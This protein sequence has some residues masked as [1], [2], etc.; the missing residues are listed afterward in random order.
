MRRALSACGIAAS[1]LLVLSVLGAYR[2]LTACVRAYAGRADVDLWVAPRGSDNLVRSTGLLPVAPTLA[3]IRATP[4]VRR[5]DPIVR[6]FV[7]VQV[8][9]RRPLTLLALGTA[10][11]GGPPR[12][13]RGRRPRRG[14]EVAFDRA[15]AAALGVEVGD[16]VRLDD[17]SVRVVGITRGTNMLATQLAFLTFD[18]LA[19]AAGVRGAASFVL[20]QKAGGVSAATLARRLRARTDGVRVFEREAFLRNN[21]REVAAGF[22]PLLALVSV[23]SLGVAILLVGLLLQGAVDDRR[24]EIAVLLAIGAGPGRLAVELVRGA[25]ALVVGAGALG[26]LA[27]AALAALLDRVLPAVELCLD[28]SDVGAVLVAFS[29][30]GAVAAVI[31]VARLRRVDPLEAFRP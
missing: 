18:G 7:R 4:G 20:V 11:L 16:P 19:S 27:A 22:L 28:P 6:G 26:A 13:E 1:T 31:P 21:V 23:L 8:P 12:L 30:A 29:F 15:A 14:D 10:G 17:R 3:A 25:T 2:S 5:A 24:T 9:G